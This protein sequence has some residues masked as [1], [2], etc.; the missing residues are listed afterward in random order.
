MG[1]GNRTQ[2]FFKNVFCELLINSPDSR[3][4]LVPGTCVWRSEDNL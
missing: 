1:A 4:V 2:V 3:E